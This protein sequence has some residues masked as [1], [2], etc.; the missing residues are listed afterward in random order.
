[1]N[2]PTYNNNNTNVLLCTNPLVRDDHNNILLIFPIS[3]FVVAIHIS[4]D[5]ED[6]QILFLFQDPPGQEL[7]KYFLFLYW[8]LVKK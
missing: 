1:M 4:L 2:G 6:I 7:Q 3:I 8:I 5:N